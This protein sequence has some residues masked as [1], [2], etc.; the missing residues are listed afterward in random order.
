MAF[1]SR[2]HLLQATALGTTHW[3]LGPLNAGSLNAAGLAL[4]TFR[5]DATPPVGHPCCGGW[6]SPVKTVEDPLDGLG[7]VLLG[8]GKPVVMCA[9]DW[10]GILNSNH[11]AWRTAL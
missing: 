2:R 7:L 10:T 8:A 11:L 4:G 1:L 9:V 3:A 5:F 6:I